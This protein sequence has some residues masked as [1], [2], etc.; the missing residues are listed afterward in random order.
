M[1]L[2]GCGPN[3]VRES[4]SSRVGRAGSVAALVVAILGLSCQT[5]E[6]F[7]DSEVN[8]YPQTLLSLKAE[9]QGKLDDI[10]QAL[11]DASKQIA[12]HGLDSPET[13]EILRRLCDGRPYVVDCSTINAEG[14]MMAVE[15][16]TYRQLEGA[17]ISDQ[18]QVKL[19]RKSK[20]P[21]LSQVFTAIEG[22]ASVDLEWPVIGADGS[23][24]GSVSVLMQPAPFLGAIVE[25]RLQGLP[26]DSWVVQTDG[27]TLYDPDEE[28]VGRNIVTDPLYDPFP[29]LRRFTRQVLRSQSGNGTYEFYRTG[30]DETVT[31]RAYWTTVS[32]HGTEWR[33]GLV[34][35]LTGDPAAVR[36][37]FT[38]LELMQCR[39]T[40]RAFSK[41]SEVV[42][43][44][45]RSNEP[46]MLDLLREYYNENSGLYSVQWLTPDGVTR[47]GFPQEN[48]LRNFDHRAGR[49]PTDTEFVA[50]TE[51]AV[52]S[53][54][55]LTLAEGEPAIAFLSPVKL[56]VE[57]V[58]SLYFVRLMPQP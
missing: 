29:D 49:K 36:R 23:F 32:L 35:V 13:R 56:G 52:E 54:I 37:S 41:R 40:L 27:L 9:I 10:D 30:S 34:Q 43:C 45:S 26:L 20:G 33:I 47:I 3:G 18:E 5:R 58:G 6:P 57:Y 25:P 46:A 55:G 24:L 28:E 22:M 19:V 21:V 51:K 12:V 4:I 38:D 44:M 39:D 2:I 50:H 8:D 16:Q 53:W 11:F 1:R 17:D 15:P 14:R 48:S 31:K 7:S 42:G